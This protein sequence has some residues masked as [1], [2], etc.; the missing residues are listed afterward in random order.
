MPPAAFGSAQEVSEDAKVGDF[1]IKAGDELVL[2]NCAMGFNTSQWQRPFEFL[3]ERFDP[4]SPLFLTP[5]GKKRLP[6]A[7]TPFLGGRR[8][9]FGKTFAEANLKIVTT[10]LT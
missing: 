1:K 9:C 4:D 7:Y 3:P 2:L 8:V 5:D 6:F 10:Y